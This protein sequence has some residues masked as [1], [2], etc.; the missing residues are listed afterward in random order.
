MKFLGLS[1]EKDYVSAAEDMK[2]KGDF[3]TPGLDMQAVAASRAQ[4]TVADAFLSLGDTQAVQA[5]RYKG[6]GQGDVAAVAACTSKIC[7]LSVSNL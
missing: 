3:T 6:K 4:G 2:R 1:S 5:A 7:K